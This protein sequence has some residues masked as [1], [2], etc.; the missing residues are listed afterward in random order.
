MA[1]ADANGPDWRAQT[2]RGVGGAPG[3]AC[4]GIAANVADGSTLVGG[5][6][7]TRV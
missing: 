4:R 6:P 2:D 7:S 1:T 5:T 3:I